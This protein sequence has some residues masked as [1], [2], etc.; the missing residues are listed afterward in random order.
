MQ[1]NLIFRIILDLLIFLAI[2]HGW[3]FVASPLALVGAWR[4]RYFAEMV[5]T[6][7]VYDS[8]FGLVPGMGIFGYLGIFVSI[9][10]FLGMILLKKV[11]RRQE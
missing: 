4:Y 2:I 7:L 6:G 11:L 10:L 1:K 8:L 3:W 5:V 9:F